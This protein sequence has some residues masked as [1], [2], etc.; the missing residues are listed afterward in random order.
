MEA[1]YENP[2]TEKASHTIQ[3]NIK[4]D[5]EIAGSLYKKRIS[6]AEWDVIYIDD[7]ILICNPVS[8]HRMLQRKDRKIIIKEY[9]RC[10][11]ASID[12]GTTTIVGLSSGWQNR[13]ETLAV[14]SRMNPQMQYGGDVIQRANY[15]LEHGKDVLSKCVQKAINKILKALL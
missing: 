14:E 13:G 1:V 11:T 9:I 5:I 7:E 4:T 15:A 8:L 12:L 2:D 6:E 10:F 3:R